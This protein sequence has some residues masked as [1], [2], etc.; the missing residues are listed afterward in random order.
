MTSRGS[1]PPEGPRRYYD[2][3][4][5]PKPGRQRPK[6]RAKGAKPAP[7]SRVERERYGLA[8]VK[9]EQRRQRNLEAASRGAFIV[10]NRPLTPDELRRTIAAQ[11][12]ARDLRAARGD[13]A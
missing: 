4:S 2:P 6:T 7:K 5:D 11:D 1:F 9:R 10:A 12:L 8:L 13:D 3:G